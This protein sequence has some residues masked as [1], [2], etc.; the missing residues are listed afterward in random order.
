M[1]KIVPFLA[2]MIAMAGPFAYADGRNKDNEKNAAAGNSQ[3]A[4]ESRSQSESTSNGQAPCSATQDQKHNKQ[5][6]A[7]PAPSDQER[8]FDKVLMGIY[9]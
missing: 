5:N 2:L 8:E 9:G 4:A 3:P 6:K 1:K 7:K